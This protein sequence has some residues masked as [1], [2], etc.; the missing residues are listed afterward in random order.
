E[1]RAGEELDLLDLTATQHFTEPPPRYT[2]ATL[3]AEME[4][5]GIGRPSTYAPILQTLRQRQYVRMQGRAFVPTRLGVAVCEYLQRFFPQIVDLQFTALMEEKLDAIESG[6]ANWVEVLREFYADLSKW[7][8]EAQK[9]EPRVLEGHLCPK[10][11]GRLLERFST[12]GRFAGCENYPKCD[13]TRDLGL[14]IDEHC[15][16][17]GSQLEVGMQRTGGL[18][19]RCSNPEC[20]YVRLPHEGEK[21]ESVTGAAQN[22]TKPCPMCGAALKLRSNRRGQ[23]FW[24]CSRYPECQYTESARANRIAIQTDIQC[25]KCGGHMVVRSSRKGT[26]LGCSNYPRCRYARKLTPDEREKYLSAEQST[27]STAQAPRRVETELQCPECS[28][29]L[30][31]RPGSRGWF[32][33]CSNYPQ[34]R[35]TRDLTPEE[36]EKY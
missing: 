22:E 4:R 5:Y 6:Q 13:Y 23:K 11:G 10:C 19:V 36:H 2:E 18:V 30:V 28:G 21:A 20:G 8:I 1:L 17:C 14:P 32:L 35:Y 3:V 24:G 29:R 12:S 15:P 34:C 16:Q 26:F 27:D 31:V 33:G 9:P 7:L 25:P